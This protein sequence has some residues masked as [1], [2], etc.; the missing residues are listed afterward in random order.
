MLAQAKGLECN[1]SGSKA[2]QVGALARDCIP[3]FVDGEDPD[4]DATYS[5]SMVEAN[6]PKPPLFFANASSTSYSVC[7][8]KVRACFN[9]HD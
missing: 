8:E 1:S 9:E 6:R 2:E 7:P 4:E 3:V 5:D